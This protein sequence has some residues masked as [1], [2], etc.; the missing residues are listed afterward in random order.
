MYLDGFW[1]EPIGHV[2]QSLAVSLRR[3]QNM[4]FLR[5][6]I[7]QE[8]SAAGNI[9]LSHGGI[10][11]MHPLEISAVGNILLSHGGISSMHPLGR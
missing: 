9:L 5:F 2:L 10:S 3:C 8:I 4:V 7:T 11:G 6:V 1:G